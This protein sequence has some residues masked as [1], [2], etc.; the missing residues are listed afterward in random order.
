[1]EADWEVEIGGG[2]PIIDAAW[3]GLVDLRRSPERAAELAEAGDLPALGEALKTQNGADSPVWTSKCDVWRPE[4][5]DR[6]EL[7]AV[8][9]EDVQAIACYIDLLAEEAEAW[10][11]HKAAVVW[12]Q[13]TCG[14]LRCRNL[15]NCRVDLVVRRACFTSEQ[16]GSEGEYGVTVY[17]TACGAT[18]SDAVARLASVLI[19]LAGAVRI[20]VPAALADQK[21]Q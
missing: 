18:Y 4:V 7:D 13:D 8:D 20:D 5:F 3:A 19:E 10:S 12:C 16:D 1:M 14:R 11:T 21:L 17:L 2:A 15:R 9:G 6:D